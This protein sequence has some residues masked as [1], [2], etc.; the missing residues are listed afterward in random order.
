MK[1]LIKFTFHQKGG[2]IA[3]GEM[4]VWAE[5]VRYAIRLVESDLDALSAKVESVT[6]I[7]DP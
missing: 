3:E 7:E 2:E 4:R 5:D 1:F 6:P